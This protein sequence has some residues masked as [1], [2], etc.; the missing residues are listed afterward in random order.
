V[1]GVIDNPEFD[2]DQESFSQWGVTAFKEWYLPRFQ[3]LRGEVNWLGR[4]QP[5]PLQPVPVQLLRGHAV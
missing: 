4:A 3:K 1:G 5:R 2:P